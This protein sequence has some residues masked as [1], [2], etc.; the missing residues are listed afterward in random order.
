M[1]LTVAQWIC[2]LDARVTILE[3]LNPSCTSAFLYGDNAPISTI[4]IDGDYYLQFQGGI[5]YKKIS[6][7]WTRQGDLEEQRIDGGEI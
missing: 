1:R 6:S 2:Y 3:S 4:G 5:L 7:I